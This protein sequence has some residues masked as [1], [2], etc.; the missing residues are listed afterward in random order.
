[1]KEVIGSGAEAVIYKEEDNVVKHRLSKGYRHPHIDAGLRKFRTRREA[2]VL[3]KLAEINFPAPRLKAVCDKQM[4]IEMDFLEGK[5]LRDVI[6]EKPEAFA[7]EIGK[8]IGILHK[9]GIIHA[10]LTTSNMILKSGKSKDDK[11]R[12]KGEIHFIDFGL[13]FFSAKAEDKAVDLHLLDRA[14]E[15]KHYK[16][17]PQIFESALEGYKESYLEHKEVLNR[18]E[19]VKMRGRNKGK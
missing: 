14:F 4:I 19:K 16:L 9:N 15:S 8:K 11:E 7:R 13:S 1:M 3:S 10:D 17:Y 18:F 5:K 2:K 6:H 12:S